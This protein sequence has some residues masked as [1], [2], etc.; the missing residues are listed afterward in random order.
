MTPQQAE[1]AWGASIITDPDDLP[2]EY[3]E[4]IRR[5]AGQRLARRE[6]PAAS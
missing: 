1:E 6:V 5:R 4:M 2:V 3:V